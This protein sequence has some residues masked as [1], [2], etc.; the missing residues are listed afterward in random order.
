MAADHLRADPVLPDDVVKEVVPGN[1]RRA[2][3][4][5]GLMRRFTE[6]LKV[7]LGGAQWSVG[8][9]VTLQTRLRTRAIQ[10][11]SPLEFLQSLN[12]VLLV[13][14]RESRAMHRR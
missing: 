2:E 12:Q 8:D 5:V 4:F 3:H 1:I 14:A 9:A 10:M 6:F 13:R 11:E 7:A